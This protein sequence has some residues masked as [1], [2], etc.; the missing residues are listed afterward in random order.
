VMVTSVPYHLASS[1]RAELRLE[2]EMA[3]EHARR[4]FRR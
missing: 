2:R 3:S 4:S 1:T